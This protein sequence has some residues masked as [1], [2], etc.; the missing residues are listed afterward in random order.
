MHLRSKSLIASCLVAAIAACSGGRQ[1]GFGGATA[2]TGPTP[3]SAAPAPS[4]S[5]EAPATP[6]GAPPAASKA[7]Q[8][9]TPGP[10]ATPDGVVFNYRPDSKP[11]QIFL[12]G[13]FNDWNPS[14]DKFLMKDDDGDGT[15]SIT[16]KLVPGSYQYKFVIDGQW[17]KDPY[18]PSDA[19]DGFGGRNGK[20]DVK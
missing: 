1:P 17:T 16:V 7:P 8:P 20:L 10:N 18:S 14:N 12:A 5:T 4:A 13:S 15:Y 2:P 19:P 9:T 11:K 3:P 6:A